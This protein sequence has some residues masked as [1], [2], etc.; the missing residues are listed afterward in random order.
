MVL[1]Y[2]PAGWRAL[3]REGALCVSLIS[4]LNV[5]GPVEGSPKAR[6]S[7]ALFLQF[8]PF[9]DA[10]SLRSD[11]ISSIKILPLSPSPCLAPVRSVSLALSLSRL[12]TTGVRG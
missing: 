8:E 12:E 2:G 4:V 9:L 5:Q 6:L 10:L 11:V 3:I 1:L 7:L